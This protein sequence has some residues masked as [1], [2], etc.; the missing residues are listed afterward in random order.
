MHSFALVLLTKEMVQ[1]DKLDLLFEIED[2]VYPYKHVFHK[3]D[4]RTCHCVKQ[5]NVPDPKCPICQGTG[6]TRQN[7]HGKF[8]YWLL[9]GRFDGYIRTG[10]T[11]PQK[12]IGNILLEFFYM[13]TA[14]Q[15][16]LFHEDEHD[17]VENNVVSVDH[18]HLKVL[19]ERW[20]IPEHGWVEDIFAITDNPQAIYKD[21]WAAGIDFHH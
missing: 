11:D 7:A 9:G 3:D 17:E 1:Q 21:Y 2:I 18:I 20:I 10:K 15:G 5:T 4:E 6:K 8:D 19:R 12:T 13:R 16:L 14:A